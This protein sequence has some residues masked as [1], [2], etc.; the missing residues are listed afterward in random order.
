[1][2][3]T[4]T[5]NRVSY[6]GDGVLLTFP[7]T[8]EI[9]VNTDLEV[10]VD[11]V[12]K[13]LTTDYTVT[14]VGAP[15]GGNVVFVAAP[16]A[17]KAVILLRVVAQTQQS[18]LPAN[19]KFPS[20]TVETALDKLT[21]LV[22]QLNE[23][24][25]RAL[26]LAITSAFANLTLPDPVAG[27]ILQWKGDLTGLQNASLTGTGLV[28]LPLA[29][30]QGGTGST[31]AAS[32]RTA[33]T[34]AKQLTVQTLTH[35]AS[36]V[37]DASLGDTY[38]LVPQEDF[39]LANP[40]NPTNGQRIIVRIKQDGVGARHLTGFGGNWRGGTD[41]SLASIVLSTAAG[42]TDY[43]GAYYDSTDNKWDVIAFIKGY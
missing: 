27:L 40:T 2:T 31:D 32:A 25:Q 22:Q 36:P 10:F 33:L 3:V 41:L 23:V 43:L 15:A 5:L 9:L 29:V 11:G 13:T 4:S 39:T 34:A 35:G 1:M 30:N 24:D 12:L 21:M 17:G 42:K 38:V 14:G 7:Y 8:F 18:S 16:G 26:K 6:T 37:I 20:T 28:A 19:D